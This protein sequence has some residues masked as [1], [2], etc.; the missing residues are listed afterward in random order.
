MQIGYSIFFILKG[1]SYSVLI[2]RNNAL[3]T[4]SDRREELALYSQFSKSGEEHLYYTV[5]STLKGLIYPNKSFHSVLYSYIKWGKVTLLIP[6]K[7]TFFST[8]VNYYKYRGKCTIHQ[9]SW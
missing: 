1:C 8:Q 7:R 6:T 9:Y 5:C 3:V 4:P 2:G